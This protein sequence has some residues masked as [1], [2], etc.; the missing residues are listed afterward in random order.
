MQ[1][2]AVLRPGLSGEALAEPQGGV[3]RE[4][5]GGRAEGEGQRQDHRNHRVIGPLPSPESQPSPP[6]L[7]VPSNSRFEQTSLY[8]LLKTTKHLTRAH[9]F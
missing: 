8:R 5:E 3:Q 4:E 7:A 6:S 2:R 1:E 9:G